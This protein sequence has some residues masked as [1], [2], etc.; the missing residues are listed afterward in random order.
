MVV[1]LC[2]TPL[3]RNMPQ[4]A[5]AAII[6]SAVAGLFNYSEAIFLWRVRGRRPARQRG[7]MPLYA[8]PAARAWPD[9]EPYH[10][11]PCHWARTAC[12]ASKAKSLTFYC[13]RD[14]LCEDSQVNGAPC[15]TSLSSP[16]QVNKFRLRE[17]GWTVYR[18]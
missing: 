18:S 16:G 14:S 10:R 4:N 11:S 5:Q 9:R 13:I 6:I 7:R 8:R 1:L 3:F 15:G 17:P 12:C 2:L